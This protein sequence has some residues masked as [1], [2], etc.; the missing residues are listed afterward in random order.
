MEV[1]ADLGERWTR[2]R[3]A[4]LSGFGGEIDAITEQQWPE[5][6]LALFDRSL[7]LGASC[8][9]FLRAGP[10]SLDEI[11]RALPTLESPCFACA[12]TSR[13]DDG[14][15]PAIALE[16]PPC[17]ERSAIPARACDAWR[18]ATDG[19][20]LGLSDGAVRLAR[21]RSRGHGA[22]DCADVL[23]TDPESPRRY[24]AM[25]DALAKELAV[26]A[27]SF[28]RMSGG[29]RVEFLGLSEKQLCFRLEEDGRAQGLALRPMLSSAVRRRL[30]DVE[31][32]DVA[33]RAV[34]TP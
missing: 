11:A 16:R 28:A 13:V 5:A 22:A 12:R 18:E 34:L 15:D 29:C 26:V 21:H 3:R 9:R 25:P 27:A 24:G 1:P 2:A 20:V 32:V 30:P 8:R 7:K 19:L 33:P 6:L 17:T 31:L 10:A 23:Y 14:L 4:A